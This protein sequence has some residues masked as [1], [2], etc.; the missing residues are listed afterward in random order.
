M[1][2]PAT[3]ADLPSLTDTIRRAWIFAY[4]QILPFDVIQRWACEDWSGNQA[5]EQWPEITVYEHEGRAVG[6]VR[7][8][9][10]DIS[11][12]FVHPSCHRRGIGTALLRHAEARVAADGYEDAEVGVVDGN[13]TAL[14]FYGAQGYA[15]LR[16]EGET[17]PGEEAAIFI[18]AKRLR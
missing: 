10:P 11:D 6:M 8:E 7:T 1:I 3:A 14:S 13:L 15:R 17:V 2:R 12:L 5:A 9:G 16:V 4:G 18:L